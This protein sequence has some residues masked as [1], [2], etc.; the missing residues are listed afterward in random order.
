MVSTVRGESS[1]AAPAPSS[2]V[3]LVGE[4]A[5]FVL[6][7]IIFANSGLFV[8]G[9]SDEEVEEEE[10]DIEEEIE[11][12]GVERTDEKAAQALLR[13]LPWAD[14]PK[15]RRGFLHLFSIFLSSPGLGM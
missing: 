8:V 4:P 6:F 10:D 1:V 5:H 2:S 13:A 12:D 9:N 7:L 3:V 11:E 15:V 14:S